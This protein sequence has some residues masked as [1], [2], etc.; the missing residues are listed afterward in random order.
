LIVI[1]WAQRPAIP[2]SDA[3]LV[4]REKNRSKRED[5]KGSRYDGSPGAAVGRVDKS[6]RYTEECAEE[7]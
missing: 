6:D 1:E 5:A 2:T 4:L 7:R 3:E